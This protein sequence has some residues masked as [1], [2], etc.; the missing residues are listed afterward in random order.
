[1]LN[2]KEHYLS[3]FLFVETD[4]RRQNPCFT[5]CKLKYDFP[6]PSWSPLYL[7]DIDEEEEDE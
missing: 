5:G 6:L 4:L 7:T 2:E 3:K 1:M